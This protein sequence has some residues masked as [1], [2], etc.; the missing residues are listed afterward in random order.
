MC[1]LPV[2]AFFLK[3]KALDRFLQQGTTGE[4]AVVE[5]GV[6]AILREQFLVGAFLDDSAVIHH[7]DHIGVSNG[8]EPV[9]ND[10]VGSALHQFSHSLLN[11]HLGTCINTTRCFVQNQ[12]F[13]I[14]QEGTRNGEQL[15]LALLRCCL[16]PR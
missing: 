2:Q 11:Q 3:Q 7:Q 12:D 15:L 16:L 5:I 14:S 13:G 10:E 6:E 4:L 9:S 8:R 1:F